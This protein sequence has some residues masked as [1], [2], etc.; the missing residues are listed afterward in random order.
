MRNDTESEIVISMKNVDHAFRI[1]EALVDIFKCSDMGG[2]LCIGMLTDEGHVLD[3]YSI[4]HDVRNPII[5]FY[6]GGFF[7]NNNR[8]PNL[9]S[10]LYK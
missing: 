4:G 10:E 7:H 1:Y 6:I 3:R 5:S 8:Q 9:V 2:D